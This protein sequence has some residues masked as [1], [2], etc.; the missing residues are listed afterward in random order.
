LP[1]VPPSTPGALLSLSLRGLTISAATCLA[2]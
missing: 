1:R 2:P